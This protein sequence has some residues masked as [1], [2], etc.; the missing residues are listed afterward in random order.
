MNYFDI[1]EFKS[2]IKLGHRLL[3][4][5]I[6]LVKIGI[7]LSDI[8]HISSSPFLTYNLKK[9]KFTTAKLL[10]MIKE[11]NAFGIVVGYPLQMDGL[12]GKSCQMVEKFVQKHLSSLKQP[13]FFQDE[14]LSTTAALKYLKEM[15]LTRKKQEEANDKLAASYILQTTLERLRIAQ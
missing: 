1:N 7:A 2:N 3:C 14:R 12:P 4:L 15:D 13:I 8:K 10:D 6:G 11:E 9:Q 5:D